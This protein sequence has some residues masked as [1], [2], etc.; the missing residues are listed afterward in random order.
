MNKYSNHKI[1]Y[2]IVNYKSTKSI[3]KI[4]SRLMDVSSSIYVVDNSSDYKRL[5]NEHIISPNKNIGFG[6]AVNLAVSQLKERPEFLFLINPDVI[7]EV[8]D[9]VKMV[10]C[11]SVTEA[12]AVIPVSL[13]LNDSIKIA[14]FRKSIGIFEEI[15]MSFNFYKKA[16]IL[17]KLSNNSH[18]CQKIEFIDASFCLVKYECFIKSGGFSKRIFMYGEDLV[19]S[20]RIK[21]LGYKI[22]INNRVYIHHPGGETFGSSKLM[23][24]KRLFYSS[25]GA[26]KAIS[27]IRKDRLYFLYIF[28]FLII[29][30]ARKLFHNRSGVCISKSMIKDKK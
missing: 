11:L 15:R 16:L 20:D 23:R 25:F 7:F 9:I 27:I 30:I 29:L 14:A 22:L 13:G 8:K 18:A 26:G 2:I 24:I 1:C 4:I 19:L 17:E 12:G 5:S 6:A 10:S 3:N 28:S 21:R